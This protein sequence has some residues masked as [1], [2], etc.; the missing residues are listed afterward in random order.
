MPTHP[1]VNQVSISYMQASFI[2][3]NLHIPQVRNFYD[4]KLTHD[5]II[6][7]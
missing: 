5:A 7:G 4:P 6:L 2:H 3:T 1:Q